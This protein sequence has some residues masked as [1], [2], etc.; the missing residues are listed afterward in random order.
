MPTMKRYAVAQQVE[1]MEALGQLGGSENLENDIGLCSIQTIEP[2]FLKH[3][4]RTGRILEAGSGRGRWVFY[5]RRKGFDVIG[6]DI[7]KS[8][9]EFGQ[10][11]D[12]SVPLEYDNV[13]KTKFADGSFAAVISLGVVE[14]FE[15]GPQPAFAEVM[16]LLKPGGLFLV[17]VPTQ[18][19]GRV[20]LFNHIKRIQ[21]AVRKLRG[22]RLAFEEYRYSRSHFTRLLKEAGF[23]IVDMAPDDFL[24]PKNMGLYTD[25]RFLHNPSVQWE[26]NT[27]GR[28]LARIANAC[29]P[30]AACSG[31]LW[32][33]RKPARV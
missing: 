8:D 29:S 21:N 5:L 1:S 28:I 13:L 17:T 7:A 19:I 27:P 16:R 15:N 18:N 31:T 3:L 23:E 11:F 26:L 33:C 2:H 30:W 12:P 22:V 25:S 32:V 6:I 9:L 24:P 20:L 10:R 14:H 4:P